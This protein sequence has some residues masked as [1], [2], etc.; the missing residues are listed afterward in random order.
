MAVRWWQLGIEMRP[1]FARDTILHYPVYATVTGSFGY[2][3][4]GVE[5]RQINYLNQRRE[6][7]LEKRKRFA[8]AGGIDGASVAAV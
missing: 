5:Q 4:M 1:F 6:V 3:L 7:L 2:W 8:A